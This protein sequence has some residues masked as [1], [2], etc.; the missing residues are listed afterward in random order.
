MHLV[1]PEG[2]DGAPDETVIDGEVDALGESR[3]PRSTQASDTFGEITEHFGA[4]TFKEY[5]IGERI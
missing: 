3:R 1:S 2:A 4:W 5:S